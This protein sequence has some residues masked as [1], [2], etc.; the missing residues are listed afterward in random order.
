MASFF[1]ILDRDVVDIGGRV[2]RFTLRCIY[3][4]RVIFFLGKT[5]LLCL[6]VPEYVLSLGWEKLCR[7]CLDD[8]IAGCPDKRQNAVSILVS[9]ESAFVSIVVCME[10]LLSLPK[11]CAYFRV[12]KILEWC[13]VFPK[14]PTDV[15]DSEYRAVYI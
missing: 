2:D 13:I 3:L 5:H 8:A 7:L 6:H 1:K 4:P 12:V 15:R 10:L 11:L 14:Q 9:D